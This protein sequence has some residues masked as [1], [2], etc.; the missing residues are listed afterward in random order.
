MRSVILIVSLL[1]LSACVGARYLPP[2]T[3][4]QS[5]SAAVQGSKA[6]IMDAAVKILVQNGYQVTAVD[7]A[8][9][10]ISTAPQPM[11]VTPGQADC[12]KVKGL[13]AS[14]DPLTYPQ[15]ET[16]VSFNILA[17]D[18]HIEVRSRIEDRLAPGSVQINLTCV[19]RG[20]LDQEM[21]DEIKAKL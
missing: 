1:L 13:L 5:A 21:L 11:Q 6:Q 12:G 19:S 3:L 10:L 17:A 20:V 9:G 4:N 7:N 16:R 18:H 15:P 14:G 2:D 8:S